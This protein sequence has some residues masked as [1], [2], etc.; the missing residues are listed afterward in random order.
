MDFVKKEETNNRLEYLQFREYGDFSTILDNDYGH[1]EGDEIPYFEIKE[2][3]RLEKD[4]PDFPMENLKKE[5]IKKAQ[6]AEKEKAFTLSI[7]AKRTTTQDNK[8]AIKSLQEFFVGNISDSI[9]KSI[10]K[11]DLNLLLRQLSV[12]PS[13]VKQ[14]EFL[15]NNKEKLNINIASRGEKSGTA[16][17][18][19][20]KF[21]D[22]QAVDLLEMHAS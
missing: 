19:A 6:A 11:R 12:K 5:S 14:L 9:K 18:V 10:E 1:L 2:A 15:L 17:D 3:S 13:Y 21:K 16:M 4:I 20:K 8:E 22:Q 7:Q